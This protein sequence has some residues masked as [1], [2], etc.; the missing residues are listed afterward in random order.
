MDTLTEHEQEL[1]HQFISITSYTD[2]PNTAIRFLSQCDWDLERAIILYFE[3]NTRANEQLNENSRRAQALGGA[4]TVP[5][6]FPGDELSVHERPRGLLENV[7]AR[8]QE[9]GAHHGQYLPVST[10]ELASA[11][12]FMG[13]SGRSKVVYMLQMMLYVP[14]VLLQKVSVTVLIVVSKLFPMVKTLTARYSHRRQGSR[15]EPKGVDPV[16]IARN[17]IGEMNV[18]YGN[19]ESKLDF[20]EGGYTSALY[21]AKR[22]ARFL[23]IYLHS[24][25]HDDTRGFVEDTLLNQRVLDFVKEHDFLIWGGNVLGS[26]AYQVANAVGATRYPF[27]CLL[28]LKTNSQETPEGTTTSAPTLSVVCKVQGNISADKLVDKLSSQVERLEP[29]LISIRTERQQNELS[30]VIREQQ[31]QA[32]QASLQRDRMI[33]EQRRQEQQREQNEQQWL[34]W[35]ATQLLPE[36]PIEQKGQYARIAIK[37]TNGERISRRFPRDSPLEE[38]YAFVQCH[39][40]GL[41]GQDVSS[42]VSK[43]QG[44][45]YIYPFKLITPMPRSELQSSTTIHIKDEPTVWPNGN[46]IMEMND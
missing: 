32:Y 19:D 8:L 27:V 5:G 4:A 42:S 28:S 17:F 40:R 44:F 6:G 21:V 31:D 14:L 45:T 25:E 2:E 7:R 16:Q 38:I 11:E 37:L 1:V 23:M 43:P 30:R 36:V 9:W 39:S 22:D 15:S 3:G 35:R 34:R 20:Y 10:N 41:I 33:A 13:L 46:L 12:N 29:T 26:E 18:F 24:D